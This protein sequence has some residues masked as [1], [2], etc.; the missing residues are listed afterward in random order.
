MQHNVIPVAAA[1]NLGIIAMKVFADGA[2]FT[3]PARWSNT[4]E[5]VVRTVGSEQLPSQPLVQYSLTT[6]GIHTAIIG[7][8][9]VDD[10]PAKCQLHQN[11]LSAQIEPDGLGEGDRKEIE[12]MALA[13]KEGKTNYFQ[14]N[15]GGLT[16]PNKPEIKQ[17]MMGEDRV[18]TLAWN[19]AIAGDEVIKG[20]EIWRDGEK[21]GELPHQPQ[22]GPS[23]FHFEDK[24]GNRSAHT[25]KI[26]TVDAAGNKATSEELRAR[27]V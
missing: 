3:K 7:I 23:P 14:V 12:Q 27:S 10:D 20:Y 24:P 1:K 26:I 22:T 21:T 19:T 17:E 16:P 13:A 15:E 5:H 18:V 2:M 11:Y 8:G 9:H 4:S 25:Y 6:P